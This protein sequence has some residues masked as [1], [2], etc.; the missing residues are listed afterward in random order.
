MQEFFDRMSEL[1]KKCALVQLWPYHDELFPAWVR[2]G[3]ELE[4]DVDVFTAPEIMDRDIFSASSCSRPR[5]F[6][7][8]GR[9][10]G[11]FLGKL[12]YRIETHLR[13]IYL[14]VVLHR[15]YD[16][17]IANS[18]TPPH[19]MNYFFRFVRMPMIVVIHTGRMLL[20]NSDYIGLDKREN[21]KIV[22]IAPFISSFLVAG[23]VAAT[24][25]HP[26]FGFERFKME[27][28]P[29]SFG[30][31]GDVSFNR[32]NYECLL[33]TAKD[34]AVEQE[35]HFHI[36]GR[37][38]EQA[39]LL[40]RRL[41]DECIAER[42]TFHHSAESYEEFYGAISRCEFILVLVDDTRDELS[43]YFKDKCTSSLN[44]AVALGVIPIVNE[45]LAH[46]FGLESCSITYQQDNTTDAVSRALSLSR[47]E[48]TLLTERL[49]AK[50]SEW[51][52]LSI[53]NLT[54]VFRNF[55]NVV[56]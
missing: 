2:L 15:K 3:E 54:P 35:A 42:F 29:N 5:C 14:L 1:R 53:S 47:A 43:A 20:K 25:I 18:V 34:L 33:Q 44:T 30:V 50:R 7:A 24:Y 27:K 37:D 21:V 49:V 56:G 4:F 46:Q 36:I 16:V 9:Q 13:R 17:V 45:K 11:S 28:S 12:W 10:S 55:M 6:R 48:K 31:Q 23:G 32:R 39:K 40:S 41:E 38:N 22:T 8:S 52:D 19:H 51:Q 26:V